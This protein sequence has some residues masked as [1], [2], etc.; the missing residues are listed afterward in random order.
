MY[1]G[2]SF[3]WA[4]I[5]MYVL[6]RYKYTHGLSNHCCHLWLY[7]CSRGRGLDK[8]GFHAKQPQ[9]LLVTIPQVQS[10]LYQDVIY[11]I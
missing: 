9:G 2:H 1:C 7:S 3:N 4:C 11:G 10:C 5:T 8:V 6:L